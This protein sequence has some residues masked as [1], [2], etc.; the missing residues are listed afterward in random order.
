MEMQKNLFV[1]YS[2]IGFI[3]QLRVDQPC[4]PI[5]VRLMLTKLLF[6]IITIV[7]VLLVYSARFRQ[8]ARKAYQERAVSSKPNKMTRWVLY[9]FAGIIALTSCAFFIYKWQLDNTVVSIRVIS[10]SVDNTTT[11]KALQKD[12]KGRTFTTLDGRLVTLGESDRIE[13]L[14][15]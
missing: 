3:V 11:Y 8:S 7:I 4:R 12:I 14:K 15:D 13:L 5:S 6:T 9:S 1:N 2:Q 10:G